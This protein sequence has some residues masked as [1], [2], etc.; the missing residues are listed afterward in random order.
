MRSACI[1]HPTVGLAGNGTN[2]SRSHPKFP[3]MVA[4]GSTRETGTTWTWSRSLFG[5]REAEK[6]DAKEQ[7]SRAV[8][9]IRAY[10]PEKWERMDLEIEWGFKGGTE[11]AIRWPGRGFFRSRGQRRAFEGRYGDDNGWAD[12]W[13]S[14]AGGKSRRG[15]AL[16][17]LYI[18]PAME[19]VDNLP[20][21]PYGHPRDTRITVWTQS[22]SFTFLARDLDKGPILAPEY[23]FFVTKAGSGKTARDLRRNWPPP[24]SKAS[25]R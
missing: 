5:R 17:L 25:A 21:F 16:S 9:Q 13:K 14:H 19:Q 3:R 11:S 12:A 7:T 8:P 20:K 1:R 10:G 22:G 18:R 2:R 6:Q 23:G 15:I 24:T 4:P